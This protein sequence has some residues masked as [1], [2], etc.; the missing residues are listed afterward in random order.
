MADNGY[1]NVS[2]SA[3]T[4]TNTDFLLSYNKQFGDF[5]LYANAGGNIK[6]N[7]LKSLQSTAY[8]LV[9]ENIFTLNNAAQ[10][11]LSSTEGL[12]R[13]EKQS[14]YGS[15]DLSFRNFLTVSLTG[16]N[17]WSSTLPKDFQSYFFGSAGLTAVISDMLSLPT[18]ISL[19]KLRG[20]IAQT[21]SDPGPYQTKE[22]FSISPGG[23][24]SKSATNPVDTL[25]PEITTS[26][27]YGLDL[28]MFQN[29]FALNL[30]TT[31]PIPRTS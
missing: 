1:F 14:L 16:R 3:F 20:S 25:K 5:T 31:R 9:N 21:G 8:P 24:I 7:N 27:E 10:G 12:S 28:S 11:G 22:Y 13:R 23:S 4:E 29:R 18:A 30:P 26:Q 17:D 19:L 6:K 15:A 2:N